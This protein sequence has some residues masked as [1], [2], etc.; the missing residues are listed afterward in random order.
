MNFHLDLNT[1]TIFLRGEKIIVSNADRIECAGILPNG[2]A[3]LVLVHKNLQTSAVERVS[4][5]PK[6]AQELV[7]KL[8]IYFHFA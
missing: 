5:P 1:K 7:N 3:E 4:L 6:L 8:H 2:L